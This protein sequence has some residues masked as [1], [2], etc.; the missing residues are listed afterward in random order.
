MEKAD[1]LTTELKKFRQH[2]AVTEVRDNGV[3]ASAHLEG[4]EKAG[5]K[6]KNVTDGEER[7]VLLENDPW[8]K[9]V[10]KVEV[11]MGT[12]GSSTRL[13]VVRSRWMFE[14]P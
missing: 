12:T 3:D 8:T 10:A 11:T 14:R 4:N 6:R 5:Q 7:R 13:C 9:S 2:L 1:Y